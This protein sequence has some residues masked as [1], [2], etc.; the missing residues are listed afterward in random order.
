MKWHR[1]THTLAAC[2]VLGA[3][4]LTGCAG[5]NGGNPPSALASSQE[6]KPNASIAGAWVYRNPH[7]N[8]AEY[9]AVLF[10]DVAVYQGPEANF[11]SASAA[12]RQHYAQLVGEE[13]RR[14]IGERYRLVS[15]PGPGVVRIRPVLIGVRGTVGGVATM[16]RVIPMGMAIN[17]MR[18]I[19]GSGGTMTGGI[20]LAVEVLDSESNELLGGAVRQFAPGA[21]DIE[22]TL[23]TDKTVKAAGA[24]AGR[25]LRDAMERETAKKG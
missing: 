2:S 14:L 15:Q 22:A 3:A 7:A 12:E 21:F 13:M 5:G 11:G 16:T 18:G 9:H 17:T 10:D 1:A 8:F 19:A 4:L 6:L 24:A 23:S 20:E 25:A